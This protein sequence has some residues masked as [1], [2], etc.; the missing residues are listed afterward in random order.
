M[1]WILFL[2]ALVSCG[3][4]DDQ[5]EFEREAYSSPENFTET[6][7]GHEIVR[8]DPD[9]WRIAPF[10]EGLV[11]EVT[12]AWPNPVQS[13]DAVNLQVTLSGTQSVMGFTLYPL[14]PE[15]GELRAPIF[16]DQGTHDFGILSIQ[17]NANELFE[18]TNPESRVDLYRVVLFDRNGNIIS[19][20][21][22]M[23]N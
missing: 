22:I 11:D 4:Q 7:N 2:S 23:V 17:F 13:T 20:G 1:F 18:F 19:Y 3:Q 16:D 21:D 6:Q 12:P 8:E 5:R 9:D 14:D 10:F 15:T